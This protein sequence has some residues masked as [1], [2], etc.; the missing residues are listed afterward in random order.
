MYARIIL[1]KVLYRF[2]V[3]LKDAWAVQN[4]WAAQHKASL[5]TRWHHNRWEIV[6]QPQFW[7][8]SRICSFNRA[9]PSLPCCVYVSTAPVTTDQQCVIFRGSRRLKTGSGPRQTQGDP[10]ET[11][12][13][14]SMW[15]VEVVITK[16]KYVMTWGVKVGAGDKGNHILQR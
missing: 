9:A 1:W 14:Y 15:R 12:T 4:M 16:S 13:S 10:T 5:T 3:L 2:N 8:F 7:C 6:P 11:L